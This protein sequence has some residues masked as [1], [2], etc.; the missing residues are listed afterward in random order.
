MA[1]MVLIAQGWQAFEPNGPNPSDPRVAFI[2]VPNTAELQERVPRLDHISRWIPIWQ[3]YLRHEKRKKQVDDKSIRL[4]F[5]R[6]VAA[7]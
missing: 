3:R 4:P 2:L 1:Q 6:F 7:A 5:R